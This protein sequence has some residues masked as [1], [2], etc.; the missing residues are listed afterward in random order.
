MLRRAI[1]EESAT[2][3]V[4]GSAPDLAT[5]S[6]EEADVG[7]RVRRFENYEVI[8]DD[9]GRPIEL[10]RGAMG[11][12]YKA[13]DVDLRRPVTLKVISERYLGDESA[14]L[15]FL[16]EARA[17]A[18]VRHPNVASVFHLGR[19]GENYFYAME[20]VDGETLES[21]IARSGR[22]QI[23]LALEI[24][25]Q[26][27][28]GLAAVHKEKL[29]H[30]DIKPSNIMVSLEDGGAVSAKIIDL[31][32]AKSL[33]EP[34][35]QTAISTPG[36][37][38]GTPEFAS[39]EQFAGIAVDIRSD[40][41]S[42]GATLWEML[43]GKTPFRGSPSE[44]M[45]QHQ[46]GPL[47][48]K[49]LEDFPQ[50]VVVLLE[51]LLEKDPGRRFQNPADLLNAIATITGAIHA[52][53]RI[54]RKG[55]QKTPSSASR[56]GTRKLPARV[57]TKKISVARLPVTGSDVFGREEDVAFLDDAWANQ[58]VNLVTI[59]AWAGV[60]KSTLV[61]HWL[62][63]MAA[64]HYRSAE[65]IFGWSFYRQGTNGDTSSPDEFLEAALNWFG[66]RDPRLGTAW[67]K[68]ERL[69]KLVAHRRTLLVLDGL[70]PLQNPPG[71]Q[72]GRLREPSLQALLRELAA[73]NMGLCLITSRT[74]V[75]DIADHERTSAPR[76]NLDQL[77]SDA[78]AKL[79]R[80]LGIQGDEAELRSASDEFS[81][82][83]LALTL[84]GS[85][86]N[87][88]YNGDIRCRE[89]VSTRLTHDVRQGVHARKVM[90]S[91]QSWLGEGPELSVLRLLGLFD[92]PADE[93]V[94]GTVLKPPAIHGLTESLANLSPTERRT[95]LAKLRRARL[96]AG[97]DP[98]NPGCLDTH[99]LIREYF[100]EQ[101]QSQRAE[102]WKECNRRLYNHYRELAPGQPESF[103]DMEPLFQAVICGCNA[104]LYREALHAVY[105]SRI[106]RGNASFAA[107]VLG[108]RGA[109]L[110]VLAHFFEHGR[111][112]S[113]VETGVEEQRLASE[114]RL[115]ILM[116]AG[117]LL[118]A[119][120]GF[121]APEALI[122]YERAESLC[123]SLNRPLL[124]YVALVGRWR[125]SLVTDKPTVTMQIAQ[126]IYSL[127][128]EQNDPVLEVGAYRALAPTAFFLGDFETAHEYAMLGVKIWRS[129]GVHSLVEEVAAPVIICLISEA[130][131]GWHFEETASY[132]ATI[133][134]AIS[135]A[136]DLND[137]YGLAQALFFAGLL[138][139]FARHPGEAERLASDLIELSTRQ[140]FAFFQAGGEVL[141]G[142]TR[143]ACRETAEGI[144]LIE[145]GIADWLA[146]GA[147]LVVPYY[148]ALKAEGLHFA[149]RSSEALEAISEAEAL[150]ERSAERWWC[151]ELRRLRGVFLTAVGAEESKIE[152]SFCEAIRIAKEQKSVSLEKRA[153]ATYSEYRRQKASGLGGGGFRLPLC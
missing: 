89:E 91:Y 18:S 78:G 43:T 121:A 2:T 14:R 86:L 136:K 102:A 140:N 134:E 23:A 46:H 48:L 144:A 72:E 81:G 21:L 19:T 126:R 44:V 51:A 101:L 138:A 104:G 75:A 151:A 8:L 54:T 116:Q 28:A 120:R 62:R 68:G 98:H 118:T 67:E 147:T 32:L 40:L 141:R 39:P 9:D 87:D 96:L 79:L 66:D 137:M 105:I 26:V 61:N 77:S 152:A 139:H 97:E 33:D 17:A 145:H 16:R 76:R 27:A 38:A 128:R 73:F 5:A 63:R 88:A 22:L 20:F 30:R 55:L 125:H 36:A 153:Q 124:L 4:P 109:L 3:A 149:D 35:A 123:R 99:P 111:W 60:G 29:V 95:V 117:Q 90:E 42:L 119:T 47:P 133:T 53:R 131:S 65:L 94:L 103:R 10:G 135:L 13:L 64:D 69:A 50:P 25:S 57:A 114:D 112:A 6:A 74:P 132:Q 24:T 113:P 45:H 130:C 93:K 52:R 129:R 106:Q 143:C 11:V 56:V 49:Q 7:S 1:R 84:L 107:K 122:C 37:F 142:W 82:H 31:G 115:F 15:R 146:T 127:A 100:G 83:C 58:E 110:L 70:E 108:A 71:P 85:Y 150:A 41:Y 148:L 12:T 80:A 92:R 59:V 34:G